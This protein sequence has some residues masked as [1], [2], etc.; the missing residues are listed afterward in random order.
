[1][2]FTPI[3]RDFILTLDCNIDKSLTESLNS[4]I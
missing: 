1:M 3:D 4:H 2:S